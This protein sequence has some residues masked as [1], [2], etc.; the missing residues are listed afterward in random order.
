MAST[1]S[2]NVGLEE[3]ANNDYI[4]IWNQP[5]NLNW[6]AIDTV[7]G[8]TT[9]IN[10]VAASGTVTLTQTQYRPRIFSIS[11]ALTANVNYQLPAGVGGT[12]SLLN[13]TTGSF[14]VTFS[15]A[16]GGAGIVLEQGVSTL[17]VCDANGTRLADAG[18]SVQL[19]VANTWTA[20]QTFS[21]APVFGDQGGSRAA[22]GL[23]SSAVQNIGTSG[24]N[25]PLLN[26]AN[27]WANGQTFTIG[28]TSTG[29][30]T[31]ERSGAPS[32]GFIGFGNAGHYLFH[33]GSNF[34][35]SAPGGLFAPTS[36]FVGNLQ[37][38]ITGSSTSCTGNAATA[39]LASSLNGSTAYQVGG[40]GIANSGTQLQL[41]NGSGSYRIIRVN[42]GN[43]TIEYINTAVSSVTH[44]FSDGGD[45]AI[46]G[47]LSKASGSFRI[48]HPLEALT[49]THDLVHSFLE[50]PKAD[51][52]YRGV[53]T[54][55]DG[56]AIVD[57]DRAAGM[58]AGTFA[59]LCQDVQCFT[60]NESGFSAVRGSVAGNEL[61]ITAQDTASID[62]VSWM[63]IG[64][65]QDPAIKRSTMCDA[66]GHVIVEPLKT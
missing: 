43:N 63:V 39:T 54:L 33:D 50:G 58:S 31:V 36:G 18:S 17:V 59:A 52:I 2:Q 23:G 24:A 61:T 66:N 60:S 35:F 65:R 16:N 51:L 12:W 9:L 10:A 22:L 21:V 28:L 57:L 11:G 25:V 45:L 29:D 7:F 1:F 62:T 26:G 41:D 48:D 5:V 56:A 47:N 27:T 46:T 37:G 14:T 49:D 53:V 64:E 19:N 34:S 55:S 44:S 6:T 15:S 42:P 40:L 30:I 8:S 13:S 32:T 4:D 3:P 38:N 20:T